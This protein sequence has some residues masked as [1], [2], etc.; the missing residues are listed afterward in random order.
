MNNID[1]EQLKKKIIPYFVEIYGEEFE[2]III[3]KINN[4]IP[5]FY[6]TIDGQKREML[7]NQKGKKFELTLKFLEFN[8]IVIP[9]DIKKT[10]GE[11]NSTYELKKI[12]GVSEL[13]N[14]Y[15]DTDSYNVDRYFDVEKTIFEPIDN[16]SSYEVDK[17]ISKLNLLGISVTRDNYNEWLMTDEARQLSEKIGNVKNFIS[18]LD[19]EYKKFDSQF[20]ALKPVIEKKEQLNIA[21]NNKYTIDFLQSIECY[22]N[23]QDQTLLNNY[24]AS[25][26]KDFRELMKQLN[27]TKIVGERFISNGLLDSFSTDSNERLN[28]ENT[29]DYIKKTIIDDRIKY[30][31]LIGIY[32]EQIPAKEFLETSVAKQNIPKQEFIDDIISKKQ[33]FHQASEDEIIKMFSNYNESIE[34][35]ESL[36]LLDISPIDSCLDIFRD[37]V[38]C[39]QPSARIQ[40]GVPELTSVLFFSKEKCLDNYVDVMF[41]HEINHTIETSLLD[42]TKDG[43]T[44]KTGF[45]ILKN[46]DVRNYERFSEITNHMIAMSVTEAMHRDGVFLFD[47][48]EKS[49][50]TGAT[51]YE[52]QSIFVTNFFERFKKEIMTARVSNDL[53]FLYNVVGKENFEALNNTVNSSLNLPMV[54][55][56]MDYYYKKETEEAKEY[57]KLLVASSSIFNSMVEHSNS[58]Q[59]EE[60]RSKI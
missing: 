6:T 47:S 2:P 36:N 18:Q 16:K 28:S 46:D 43:L 20:A 13:L 14:F 54:K 55:A 21:V 51:S 35:L 3:D 38:V 17:C 39:V 53:G 59:F 56:C 11:N 23:E 7:Q 42:C 29:P 58:I 57:E 10:A 8:N 45:E 1:F 26:N 15:F 41:I 40:N 44:C 27:I 33:H 49:K 12:S 4:I 31:K 60:A 25:P 50:I 34:K 22:M 30:Y 48:K 37:G 5:I 32:D 9:D 24:L 52:E 19:D